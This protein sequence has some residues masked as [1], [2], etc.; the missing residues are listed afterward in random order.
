MNAEG[1]IHIGHL[2]EE[3]GIP[4]TADLCSLSKVKQET[5][6]NTPEIQMLKSL[7]LAPW[8]MFKAQK[9]LHLGIIVFA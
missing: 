2:S 8:I 3:E 4:M 1:S 7:L 9:I 6:I 5:L